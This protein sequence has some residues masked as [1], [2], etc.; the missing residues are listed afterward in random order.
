MYDLEL[1]SNNKKKHEK[2]NS[3]SFYMCGLQ[4]MCNYHAILFSM[5]DKKRKK[6][7]ILE[8]VFIKIFTNY[9]KL[10][11]KIWM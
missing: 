3:E 6:K 4:R 11:G 8:F 10:P 9:T 7:S 1:R 5:N 2:G